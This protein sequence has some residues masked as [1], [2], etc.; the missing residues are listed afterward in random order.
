MALSRVSSKDSNLVLAKKGSRH[1]K[2]GVNTRNLGYKE[3]L[4]RTSFRHCTLISVHYVCTLES[5]TI[6]LNSK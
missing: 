4:C 1:G 6:P 3:A 5:Y 2:Q